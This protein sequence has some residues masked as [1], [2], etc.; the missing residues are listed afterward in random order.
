MLPPY[1]GR[2]DSSAWSTAQ[3]PSG[4]QLWLLHL[5]PHVQLKAAVMNTCKAGRR[6][7]GVSGAPF[8]NQPWRGQCA[9]SSSMGS[10]LAGG[11][12]L[13]AS[14]GEGAPGSLPTL[15][16]Q[17]SSSE[18]GLRALLSHLTAWHARHL[19]FSAFT[20]AWGQN[21]YPQ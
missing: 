17:S 12:S 2:S 9:A 13:A 10:L 5:V 3:P 7:R 18:P 20:Q 11:H 4:H 14:L 15:W 16:R 6:K 21:Q 8:T 19:L 1:H